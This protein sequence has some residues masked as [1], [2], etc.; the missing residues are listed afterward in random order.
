L[1]V[2]TR[3]R[4]R[5]WRV[6]ATLVALAAISATVVVVS[7]T[8]GAASSPRPTAA[9]AVSKTVQKVEIVTSKGTPLVTTNGGLAITPAL[10]PTPV[11]LRTV[12]GS[13]GAL[14]QVN[15]LGSIPKSRI[16]RISSITVTCVLSCL[17]ASGGGAAAT[18]YV[19]E[20]PS[21]SCAAGSASTN[22]VLAE[23]TVNQYEPTTEFTYPT[24]LTASEP[25]AS[26]TWCLGL[27]SGGTN[28]IVSL[29]GSE[30]TG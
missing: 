22:Q 28:L 20:F 18:A 17:F 30:S 16:I 12:G 21:S 19:F 6:G 5:W 27:A 15:M 13:T 11:Q 8:L 7:P 24:P 14:T 3:P 4:S 9:R 1:A 23:I 26:P 10:P 2:N 25:G 29:Q